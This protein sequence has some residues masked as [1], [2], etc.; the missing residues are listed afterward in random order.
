MLAR[1]C[2]A[3]FVE[4][5]LTFVKIV[6]QYWGRRLQTALSSMPRRGNL[7]VEKTTTTVL[8]PVG[9]TLQGLARGAR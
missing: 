6:R 7:F 4:Q 3:C 1:A 8:C 5:T 9:A 2:R